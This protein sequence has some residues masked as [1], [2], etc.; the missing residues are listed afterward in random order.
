MPSLFDFKSIHQQAD[1][2]Q[3]IF[4]ELR[5]FAIPTAPGTFI[6]KTIWDPLVFKVRGWPGKS[7]GDNWSLADG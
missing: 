1:F 4:G 3:A 2:A 5:V 7:G 6:A